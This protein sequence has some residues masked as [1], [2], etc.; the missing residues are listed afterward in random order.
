MHKTSHHEPRNLVDT[1]RSPFTMA[2]VRVNPMATSSPF[3]SDNHEA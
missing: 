2:E 3:H 1:A